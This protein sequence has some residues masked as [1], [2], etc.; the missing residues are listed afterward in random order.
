MHGARLGQQEFTHEVRMKP[1]TNARSRLG[2][3]AGSTH[4]RL[5]RKKESAEERVFSTY[6][7][8]SFILILRSVLFVLCSV[9]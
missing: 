5:K 9:S 2:Q 6:V 3:R 8:V 4:E 1:R 7:S